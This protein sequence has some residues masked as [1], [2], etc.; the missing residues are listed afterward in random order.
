ENIQLSQMILIQEKEA[1][2]KIYHNYE[3]LI[4]V[5]KSPIKVMNAEKKKL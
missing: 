2:Q 1:D 5:R 3:S 4:P